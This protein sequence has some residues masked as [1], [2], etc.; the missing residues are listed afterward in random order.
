MWEIFLLI[1]FTYTYILFKYTGV[2]LFNI[3]YDIDIFSSF[4]RAEN[5]FN[6]DKSSQQISPFIKM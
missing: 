2:L 5:N 3:I 4:R 1:I 6:E